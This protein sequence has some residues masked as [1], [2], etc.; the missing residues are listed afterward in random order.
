MAHTEAVVLSLGYATSSEQKIRSLTNCLHYVDRYSFISADLH[1]LLGWTP[2]ETSIP[3]FVA[4][5]HES[6]R[7]LVT[8]LLYAT[9]NHLQTLRSNMALNAG[10]QGAVR[11]ILLYEVLKVWK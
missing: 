10:K 1:V 11:F 8:C 2:D 3:I 7:R 5:A 9:S 6:V 4:P